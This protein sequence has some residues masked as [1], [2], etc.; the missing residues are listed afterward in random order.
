MNI[1]AAISMFAMP[2]IRTRWGYQVA[3]LFPAALMAV[4]FLVFAAGKPFYA[5]EVI[6][7][8]SLTREARRQRWRVLR[9]IIGL[10]V[11]IVFFWSIFE[12]SAT[13]LTLFARDHLDLHLFGRA[14]D[15][16]QIQSLNPVLVVLLLAPVTALWHLLA[17]LGLGL[18]ATDKM[19]VG[20]VLTGLSMAIMSAAGFVAGAEGRVSLWW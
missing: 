4:S 7:R 5:V 19:L 15:A 12:Q 17:R 11:V 8:K 20:F 6:R 3:F 10:Y 18:R 1:G 9:R 16:D 13:T 14:L 2:V